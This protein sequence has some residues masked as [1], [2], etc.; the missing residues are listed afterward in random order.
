MSYTN[1]VGYLLEK[2]IYNN[3]ISGS[4]LRNAILREHHYAS[5]EQFWKSQEVSK[6]WCKESGHKYVKENPSDFYIGNIVNVCKEY[7]VPNDV[8]SKFV[9]D[10][11]DEILAAYSSEERKYIKP[12]R[13]QTKQERLCSILGGTVKE[14]SENIYLR[15]FV[16]YDEKRDVIRVFLD[17]GFEDRSSDA[18]KCVSF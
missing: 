9:D 10:I 8:T 11:Y 17:M 16:D 12:P 7:P 15:V 4:K 5:V 3:I 18:Y 1:S 13:V 14:P 2:K 6:E